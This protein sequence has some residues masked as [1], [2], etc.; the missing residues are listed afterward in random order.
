M[1]TK[2]FVWLKERGGRNH[3]QT[4][5]PA[6]RAGISVGFLGQVERDKA[7]PSLGN[8]ASL[9]ASLG[10]DVDVFIAISKPADSV[11]R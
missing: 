11:I 7:T 9:A 1:V 8:L 3:A 6:D 10:I 4:D 2:F 5:A